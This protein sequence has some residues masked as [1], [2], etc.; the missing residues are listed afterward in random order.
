MVTAKTH[1]MCVGQ[2][3]VTASFILSAALALDARTI[4]CTDGSTNTQKT[5]K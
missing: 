4:L 5:M 2:T 1:T 3:D